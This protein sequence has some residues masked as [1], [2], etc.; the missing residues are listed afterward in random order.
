MFY[1]LSTK[2]RTKHDDD[3]TINNNNNKNNKNNNN[4][5]N[6]NNIE[7]HALLKNIITDH[8]IIILSWVDFQIDKMPLTS[9]KQRIETF[10]SRMLNIQTFWNFS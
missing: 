5:N 2:I 4:N 3:K 9:S 1:C 8:N 6:N 10:N 7:E